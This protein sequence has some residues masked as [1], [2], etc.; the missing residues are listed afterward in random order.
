MRNTAQIQ[1]VIFDWAGTVIDH[2]SLAPVTVFLDVFYKH[3]LKLKLDQVRQFMGLAKKDHIRSLLE[4]PEVR[5]QRPELNQPGEIPRFT[6]ELYT[7]FL[8]FQV[9][10]ILEHCQMIDGIP[11]MVEAL[12]ARNIRIGSTTGYP[13]EIINM[14]IPKAAEQ[15][16]EP[17]VTY[18]GTEVASGRPAPWM[19]YQVAEGL[20]IY[21]MDLLI[22]VDDT[23]A[24]IE[25]GV[26]AG[27]W[28]IGVSRTGNLIG[29]SKKEFESLSPEEQNRRLKR[30]EVSLK[31]AGADYVVESAA[32]ILPLIETINRRLEAGERRFTNNSH[33]IHEAVTEV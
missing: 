16:F 15:G 21:P 32:D 3:N 10:S 17:E 5:K 12:K 19:I 13:R 31:E 22:K 7:D 8:E 25:A 9:E 26:Y 1:A 33:E 30:A 2:G 11:Q 18:T 28:T 20:G 29:L 23:L 4:L 14:V 27:C 6:E 24:G